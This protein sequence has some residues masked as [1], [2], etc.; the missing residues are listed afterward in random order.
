MKTT[1]KGV[2]AIATIGIGM[3]MSS[4]QKSEI[5]EP[6]DNAS[7]LAQLE[8]KS[9]RNAITANVCNFDVEPQNNFQQGA[10]DITQPVA[11]NIVFCGKAN[12]IPAA[13]DNDWYVFKKQFVPNVPVSA[14]F[15]NGTNSPMSVKLINL[16]NNAQVQLNLLPGATGF[17]PYNGAVGPVANAIVGKY[18]LQIRTINTGA[19]VYNFQP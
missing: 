10:V 5:T 9:H 6:V 15:K 1:I 7:L 13:M 19:G 8:Q 12:A 2:F 3:I 11:L 4:C 18:A 14:M 17:I 16:V